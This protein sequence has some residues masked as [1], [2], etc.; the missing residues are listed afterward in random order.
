MISGIITAILLVVFI[1]A[2][3]WAWRPARKA[4][5]N[6]AAQLPLQEDSETGD[7]EDK[8]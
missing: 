7:Q 4:S 6:A 2:W 5:F 8:P 1:G 3:I